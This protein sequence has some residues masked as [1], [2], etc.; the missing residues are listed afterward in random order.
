MPVGGEVFPIQCKS[1]FTYFTGTQVQILTFLQ[2]QRDASWWRRVPNPSPVQKVLSLLALLVQMFSSLLSAYAHA[3]GLT[4]SA[5]SL[6]LLV[7]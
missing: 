2:D 7:Q 3:A 4:L 1:E 5:D 6:A